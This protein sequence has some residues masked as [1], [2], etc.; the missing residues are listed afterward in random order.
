M[1]KYQLVE[2][3]HR[4]ENSEATTSTAERVLKQWDAQM[5]DFGTKYLKRPEINI[6]WLRQQYEF[7]FDRENGTDYGYRLEKWSDADGKWVI[8]GAIDKR[9]FIEGDNYPDDSDPT[10]SLEIGLRPERYGD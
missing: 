7:G 10:E 3:E 9:T 4:R 6:Y 8:V 2:T 1:A 5:E